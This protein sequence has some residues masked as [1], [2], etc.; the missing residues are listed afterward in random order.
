MIRGAVN[1]SSAR[2]DERGDMSPTMTVAAMVERRGPRPGCAELRGFGAPT[3]PECGTRTRSRAAEIRPPV[4]L[5][6]P[7]VMGIGW[8]TALVSFT[9]L[10]GNGA[11][12]PRVAR[13]VDLAHPA[14][15]YG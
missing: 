11:I 3:T 15:A 10:D 2:R 13:A 8:Q 12:E 6:P 9:L 5:G 4:L 14:R 7:A 1:A